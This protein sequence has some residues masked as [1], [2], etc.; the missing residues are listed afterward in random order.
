MKSPTITDTDLIWRHFFNVAQGPNF[1]VLNLY[2][3]TKDLIL[4]SSI[5]AA[6]W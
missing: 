1:L 6:A 4:M 5:E 3:V 2:L